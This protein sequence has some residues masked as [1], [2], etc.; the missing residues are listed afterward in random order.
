MEIIVSKETNPGIHLRLPTVFLLNGLTAKIVCGFLDDK[1]VS[2]PRSQM[3]VLFR[4][5][6]R[7]RKKHPDWKLV[8]VVSADGEHVEI[9][10]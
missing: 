2:I 7:Y 4:E 9:V 1:G 5:L 3:N 6:E 8:E 10:I